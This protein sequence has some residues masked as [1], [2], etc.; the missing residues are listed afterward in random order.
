MPSKY[1]TSRANKLK[2]LAQWAVN[3]PKEKK[4]VEKK[5]KKP[6]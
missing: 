1:R 4:E 3:K 6:D 2:Q 5:K